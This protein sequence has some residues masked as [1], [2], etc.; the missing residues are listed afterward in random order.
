MGGLTAFGVAV[1][2]DGTTAPTHTRSIV[3]TTYAQK[4]A[5]DPRCF[6]PSHQRYVAG[7]S[8][9]STR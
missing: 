4:C 3:T 2:Q 7:R 1:S 5:A 6:P 9:R 8:P